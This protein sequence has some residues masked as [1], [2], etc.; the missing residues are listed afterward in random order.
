MLPRRRS[1]RAAIGH[2]AMGHFAAIFAYAR[3]ALLCCAVFL[4]SALP[5][6][7]LEPKG[8]G[9]MQLVTV[10]DGEESRCSAVFTPRGV[11]MAVKGDP[12]IP[13]ISRFD[14]ETSLNQ[15][16]LE[17][18]ATAGVNVIR[19][20]AMM[21]GILPHPPVNGV[22]KHD[23]AYIAQL[24]AMVNNAAKLGIYTLI[25]FHQD[26]LSEF[27]CGEGIPRW[28][29]EELQQAFPQEFVEEVVQ[30]IHMVIPS[31]PGFAEFEDERLRSLIRNNLGSS[32][33]PEPLSEPFERLE[34]SSQGIYSQ[35][36]CSRHFWPKYQWS[37][38][39]GHAY[40]RLFNLSSSTFHHVRHYW[41]ILAE[42]FKGDPNVLAF[43]VFNEP[44]PG[45]FFTEP[46]VISPDKAAA[47]LMPFY[48]Q[49]AHTIHEIDDERL[50][51]FSPVT[52]EEG[53]YY[54]RQLNTPA[55]RTCAW[56]RQVLF[57]IPWPGC[58][59]FWDVVRYLP[60]EGIETTG[61]EE[62]PLPGKSILSFHFYTP[63]EINP[64]LYSAKR[65]KDAQKLGVYPLLSETCCLWSAT[66]MQNLYWFEKNQIGWIMWEYKHQANNEGF[67]A[68]ITGTGPSMFH[69]D[70]TP[71]KNHWRR[72]AHPTAQLVYG[73]ILANI[74]DFTTG[75]FNFTFVPYSFDDCSNATQGMDAVIVWPW[76]WWAYINITSQPRIFV[77]PPGA[78]RVFEA[79]QGSTTPVVRFAVSVERRDVPITVVLAF[80][81]FQNMDLAPRKNEL[82]VAGP[83]WAGLGWPLALAILVSVLIALN[84]ICCKKCCCSPSRS[85][86]NTPFPMPTRRDGSSVGD[87]EVPL[88]TLGYTE[89]SNQT[90][91]MSA[92]A[93]S[94]GAIA[95]RS[96]L[97]RDLAVTPSESSAGGEPESIIFVPDADAADGDGWGGA[98]HADYRAIHSG[99]VCDGRVDTNSNGNGHPERDRSGG[100]VEM[101]D[102]VERH[103]SSPRATAAGGSPTGSESRNRV[104]EGGLLFDD[105]AGARGGDTFGARNAP[106]SMQFA[107]SSGIAQGDGGGLETLVGL[108]SDGPDTSGAADLDALQAM[109]LTTPLFATAQPT[110]ARP[111]QGHVPTS[112]STSISLAP[113]PLDSGPLEA[114][115]AQAQAAAGSAP[116]SPAA[117]APPLFASSIGGEPAGAISAQ[118]VDPASVSGA[119][120]DD[121]HGLLMG[122]PAE[123]ASS[124]ELTLPPL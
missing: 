12:W 38:A 120:A 43:D 114:T 39:A 4:A 1:A 75:V 101:V 83:W 34:N 81:N 10:L 95:G 61:F 65:K 46:W 80:A 74:F 47:R 21:P 96:P 40:R 41:K 8:D 72:L 115:S 78:A 99:A 84:V 32:Q 7:R 20:G 50:V 56:L 97:M 51:T 22:Y 107:S 119:R 58:E 13:I 73:D 124:R 87:E 42:S 94:G 108:S 89:H 116:A 17:L 103:T 109:E 92:R 48:R 27:Y 6:A 113:P 69:A 31:I 79:P 76:T 52:W 112:L 122:H 63:P 37:Y 57:G 44:V 118:S 2:R 35:D 111:Q 62:A 25:E 55:V 100:D 86:V 11:S 36:D 19:L 33:F 28:A 67:G 24:K 104:L 26:V 77:T 5:R 29:G 9:S 93:D 30:L 88:L 64:E 14:R 85:T 49:I 60:S 18:L 45:S 70:S 23:A 59:T 90:S 68:F 117:A 102:F 54:L 98:T 91:A 66:G 105:S 53:G 121:G 16:D 82:G 71:I 15:Y 123:R 110:S 106:A 3:A